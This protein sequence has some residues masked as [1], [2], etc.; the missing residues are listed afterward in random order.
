MRGTRAFLP[1]PTF[2]P[3]IAARLAVVFFFLLDGTLLGNWFVRI[4]DVQRNLGMDNGALGLALLGSAA[5]ALCTQPLAGWMIA[6]WGSRRVTIAG[7]LAQCGTIALPA[8]A[9]GMLSLTIALIALGAATGV[10]DVA[11]NV[12]GVAVE[13]AW[14]RPIMP[15]FHAFYSAGGLVGAITAGWTAS[16]GV[17]PGPHLAVTGLLFALGALVASRWLITVPGETT[18]GGPSFARP[19][20]AL[21]GLG[22]VAF[23]VVLAEGA[24]GDWSA[25]YMRQ[26]LAATTGIAAGGYAAFSLTMMLGRLGGGRVIDLAGEVAVVRVGG[27]LVA[28]GLAWALLAPNPMIALPG[29]ACVGLG[30]SCAFPIAVSA[31]GR[32]P[33]LSPGAAVAAINTAGYTGFLAGPPVIGFAAD[34]FGLATSL[35]MLA[36]VGAVMVL[37][38]GV[39]SRRDRMPLPVGGVRVATADPGGRSG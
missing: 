25:V 6:R 16:Q 33:G 19:S 1:V 28:C 34:R 8:I 7:A 23:G 5:G 24:I 39:V 26:A 20:R 21:L 2:Q 22:F 32:M 36:T 11:M 3:L 29:F 18:S 13:R 27:A 4:P 37:M 38:A 31:A 10:I 35:G 12:Q 14:G 30:L 17:T 9:P 15:T